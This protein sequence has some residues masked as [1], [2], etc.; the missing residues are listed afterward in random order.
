ML[1][2]NNNEPFTEGLNRF[3]YESLGF[4]LIQRPKFRGINCFFAQTFIYLT[5][6]H[7][8]QNLD[9]DVRSLSWLSVQN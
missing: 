1:E 7:I 5:C 6:A 3:N 2:R 8:L 4:K 9:L